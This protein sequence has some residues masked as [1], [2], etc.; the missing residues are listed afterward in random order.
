MM[1][2]SI[3][4]M[5]RILSSIRDIPRKDDTKLA[6]VIPSE[7]EFN[8]YDEILP[9]LRRVAEISECFSADKEVS[10][11]LV[12]LNIYTLRHKCLDFIKAGG[13]S[14]TAQM[15]HQKLVENLDVR[16]PD[17][18]CQNL[19]YSVANFLNPLYKERALKKLGELHEAYEAL[20]TQFNAYQEWITATRLF[21]E[22]AEIQGHVS[23]DDPFYNVR[24]EEVPALMTSYS[25]PAPPAKSDIATEWEIFQN[26]QGLLVWTC[27]NFGEQICTNFLSLLKLLKN[28]YMYLLPPHL[29]KEPLVPVVELSLIN[30]QNCSLNKLKNCC[31]FSKTT[32]RSRSKDGF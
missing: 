5:R 13:A 3:A 24:M 26:S 6:S 21:N 2:E 8:L 17:T 4:K 31:T 25:S 32:I 23:E 20:I 12:I 14:P 11:H 30:E 15:F 27:W 19:F 16:F 18:G 1:L 22:H 10:I 9:I 28:G 29:Q 7:D